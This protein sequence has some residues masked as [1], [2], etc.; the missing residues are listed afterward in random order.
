MV[1][2]NYRNGSRDP[3]GVVANALVALDARGRELGATAWLLDDSARAAAEDSARRWRQ[4]VPR[5]LE[6]VP[7]G[8]KD[9]IQ[10]AGAPTQF[11]SPHYSGFI[12]STTAQ[13]VEALCRAGAI[14]VAKL[15]TYE[16]ACGPITEVLNPWGT[17]RIAGGSSSGPCAAVAAG[18]VPFAVGTDTGGSVRVPAAWCGVVGI[19]PTFG[20][21]SRRGVAPLS[22]TLDHV[23]FIA[24]TAHDTAAILAAAGGWDELDSYSVDGA[25][26]VADS[27][28]ERSLSGL[29]VGVIDNWF[30]DDC[31]EDVLRAFDIAMDVIGAD[32]AE[33]A[34]VG[35]SIL[36]GLNPD[37]I[38]HT[39]VEAETA[40]FHESAE[41]D[42][43]NYGRVFE[44][45]VR[46]G[47]RQSTV[48][49][50]HA[51]RLCAVVRA[52]VAKV[53]DRVDVIAVPTSCVVAPPNGIDEM[54]IAGRSRDIGD[55][56]ARNTSIFNIAG[57]PAVTVPCGF[58][59]DG[60]PIGLQIVTPPWREGLGLQVAHRFQQS[61]EHHL[62]APA[63]SL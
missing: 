57:C 33:V 9:N 2:A 13:V 63:Q 53:F 54:P 58:D 31:Q 17:D 36:G 43:G 11:G 44:S 61:T 5:P 45:V 19:K 39:I 49:Y 10:I 24:R 15:S 14:P 40:S 34:R 3:E 47:R 21:V 35:L 25:P 52:E 59:H 55:L 12:P 20:R 32:G 7:F 41:L 18:L 27:S 6:G 62:V 42:V 26:F 60:M 56:V 37:A 46:A 48:D 16:F 4:G 50:L 51:M 28:I 8:V 30:L 1:L 29:R 23:G 22:W 38:K